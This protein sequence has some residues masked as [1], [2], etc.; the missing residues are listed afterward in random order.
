MLVPNRHGSSMAY[1]YGFQGQEKDD[2]IKGEGNSLNYTFRMHDPRIGRFFAIDPMT[3]KYPF[4]S[5]YSFSGNKVIAFVE[6]EGGEDRWVVKDNAVV[7]E[8]GPRVGIMDNKAVAIAKLEK[9]RAIHRN[10]TPHMLSANKRTP[11]Q[12]A[13][14]NYKVRKEKFQAEMYSNPGMMQSAQIWIGLE[15]APK[16]IAGEVFLEWLG[17]AYKGY[18]Q[19]RAAVNTSKV[20]NNV[21][22]A[23]D[24]AYHGMEF[25]DDGIGY[26]KAPLEMQA[27]KISTLKSIE[28]IVDENLSPLIATKLK[29]AGYTIKTF[30]AGV[31]ITDDV[32]IQYAK[33]NNAVVL[34][35]NIKDFKGK[36]INTISVSSKLQTKANVDRVVE[37]VKNADVKYS[38]GE[39]PSNIPL[40]L[41][42]N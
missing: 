13:E 24:A 40:V 3:Q 11:A 1:R 4:Y 23:D 12:Q 22:K 18:K 6:L 15:E 20:L 42:N 38:S 31:G 14:I 25:L 26:V 32:I 5:T 37:G 36:G 28:I 21:S 9:S 17:I 34:T 39:L 35:N 41:G 2:E 29:D 30:E 33:K 16:I 8:R 7:H 10:R 27:P 19:T